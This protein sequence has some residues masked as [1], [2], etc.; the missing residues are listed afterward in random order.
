MCETCDKRFTLASHLKA[1]TRTHDKTHTFTCSE[2]GKSFTALPSL[3][4]HLSIHDPSPLLLPP[5]PTE[6]YDHLREGGG[7]R[8][9]DGGQDGSVT[10]SSYTN[11]GA[12]SGADQLYH[13]ATSVSTSAASSTSTDSAALV[14][15]S[16][17]YRGYPS[18]PAAPPPTLHSDHTS[19]FTSDTRNQGRAS[20]QEVTTNP[21]ASTVPRTNTLYA[22]CL[23]I[24]ASSLGLIK[25]SPTQFTQTE[26]AQVAPHVTTHQTFPLLGASMSPYSFKPHQC[27]ECERCFMSEEVLH[28]HLMSHSMLHQHTCRE[29][30]T[31]FMEENSLKRHMKIHQL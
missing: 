30:A 29:C 12:R 20:Q 28:L 22:S 15:E 14:D 9:T 8:D 21:V 17:I 10:P 27:T 1:H 16:D 26:T 19:V 5:Q 31:T 18:F 6:D 11:N 23:A 7:E 24:S 4:R 3:R 25:Y 2:C 13:R